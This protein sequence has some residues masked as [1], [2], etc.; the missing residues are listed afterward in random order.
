MKVRFSFFL[1]AVLTSCV[2]Q[3][4]T[5]KR[6]DLIGSVGI[7]YASMKNLPDTKDEFRPAFSQKVA[8]EWI[9]K[10]GWIKNKA[11][12]GLGFIIDN[13]FGGKHD[14]YRLGVYN[15][16]YTYTTRKENSS[17]R[18]KYEYTTYK[19]QRKGSGSAISELKRD[20]L[21]AIA[22]TTFHYNPISKLDTYFTFGLG[23]AVGFRGSGKNRNQQG[24]NSVHEDYGTGKFE[25]KEHY[26]DIDHVKWVDGLKKT[27]VGLAVATFIGARWWFSDKLAVN[28]EVGM[29]G[30]AFLG[31]SDIADRESFKDAG[32]KDKDIPDEVEYG[33]SNNIFSVGI[34]YRF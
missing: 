8:L 21:K 7:G 6:G 20:D 11:A 12:L 34:S 3:A 15:Y 10:D 16:T 13:A 4:Q 27:K 28:A 23:V 32:L 9:I 25:I 1:F 14:Q 5:Y 17:G 2:L 31:K 22:A 24:F 18:P 29:L 30:A 33:N 26:D 19:K